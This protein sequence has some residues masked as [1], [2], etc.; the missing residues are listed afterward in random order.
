MSKLPTPC[1]CS[2]ALSLGLIKNFPFLPS[3]Q[4]HF[5]GSLFVSNGMPFVF[6]RELESHQAQLKGST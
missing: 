5:I 2:I 6:H 1:K 4:N 3:Y